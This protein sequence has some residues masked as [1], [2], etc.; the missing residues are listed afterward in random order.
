M[1]QDQDRRDNDEL[2]EEYRL[3][4]KLRR[5]EISEAEYDEAIEELDESHVDLSVTSKKGNKR[6]KKSKA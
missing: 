6:K 1:L 4:K 3:L 5:K 2:G